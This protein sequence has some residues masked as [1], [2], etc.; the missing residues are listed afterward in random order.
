M[1]AFEIAWRCKSEV[2]TLTWDRVNLDDG[3]LDL[4]ESLG[5]THTVRGAV[6]AR[7]SGLLP[8]PG[9]RRRAGRPIR[10]APTSKIR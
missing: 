7:S 4:D 2:L 1:I 6:N 10:P 3:R 5:S 8:S 9:Y